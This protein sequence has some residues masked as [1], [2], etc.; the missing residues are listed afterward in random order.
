MNLQDKID[1]A[2]SRYYETDIKISKEQWLE[3]IQDPAIFSEKY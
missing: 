1:Q 3:L 2:Y